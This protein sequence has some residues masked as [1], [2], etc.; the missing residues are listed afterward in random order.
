MRLCQIIT[1]LCVAHTA[2]SHAAEETEATVATGREVTVRLDDSQ[3]SDADPLLV[4]GTPQPDA[5]TEAEPELLEAAPDTKIPERPSGP[6][7]RVEHLS[8]G[9]GLTDATGVKIVAPFPAKP[10]SPAPEGWRFEV[11]ASVPPF[12]REVEISPGVKISLTI[13]PH[14]LVPDSDGAE[15]FSIPEPGYD[16]GLGYQQTAT[17]GAILSQSIRQVEKDS[18]QLSTAIERLQQLLGSLPQVEPAP[19]AN[20]APKR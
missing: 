12:T 10:M 18:Q 5:I 7:V 6:E 2:I 15:T 3:P 14:L 20:P 4:K 11:S 17:V 16:S 19:Q 1:L 8:P 13:R 9:N